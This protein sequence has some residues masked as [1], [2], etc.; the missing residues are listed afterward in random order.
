VKL[1]GGERQRLAIA[2]A[3]LRNPPI[4][5]LD[6]ATSSLDTESERMVQMA[7][8]N[9]MQGRTTFVIAHRLSTIQRADRIVV[10]E[11]GRVIQTGRHESLLAIDG[12]YKRLYQMQFLNDVVGESAQ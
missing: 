2:R 10:L 9:L 6:E 4:L 5:I 11:R 3:L 8:A 7:L 12:T 1:S